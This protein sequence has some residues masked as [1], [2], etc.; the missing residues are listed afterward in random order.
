M[1]HVDHRILACGVI[2]DEQIAGR[3]VDRQP[4]HKASR[5]SVEGGI[6]GLN[7]LGCYF[8]DFIGQDH[9][10]E[11]IVVLVKDEVFAEFVVGR[12][13]GHK[14]NYVAGVCQGRGKQDHRGG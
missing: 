8:T 4:H 1:H 12:V 3:V 5:S 13:K 2:S 6:G 14:C 10:D 11:E 9:A 7:A